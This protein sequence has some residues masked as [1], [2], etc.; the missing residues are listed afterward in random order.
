[1]KLE[2]EEILSKLLKV[3]NQLQVSHWIAYKHTE[4]Q[5]IDMALEEVS[6]KVDEFVEVYQGKFSK[7]LSPNGTTTI[8]VSQD[9]D[10][11]ALI[12]E[13]NDIKKFL[14][15]VP[16]FDNDELCDIID[17]IRKAL[18]TLQHHLSLD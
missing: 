14:T 18:Y 8:E 15:M 6:A 1:M 11:S 7:R 12:G 5:Y 16:N 9:L 17:D 3:V 13:V 4:H 10:V 2:K